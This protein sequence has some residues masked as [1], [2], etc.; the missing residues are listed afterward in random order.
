M[1]LFVDSGTLTAQYWAYHSRLLFVGVGVTWA[2]LRL[3]IR[4]DGSVKSGRATLS[5]HSWMSAAW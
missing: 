5:S 2:I 3:E 1:V 4:A